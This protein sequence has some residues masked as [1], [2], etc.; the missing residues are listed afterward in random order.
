LEEIEPGNST[1]EFESVGRLF[2]NVT[3]KTKII[4]ESLLKEAE[5]FP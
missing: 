1:W 3:K 2:V 5:F 4:W